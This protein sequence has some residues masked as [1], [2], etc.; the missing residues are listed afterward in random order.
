MP[1]QLAVKQK[2]PKPVVLVTLKAA[3]VAVQV[4]PEDGQLSAADPKATQFRLVLALAF[5][6]QIW[7]DTEPVGAGA[8]ARSRGAMLSVAVSVMDA[9]AVTVPVLLAC[10]VRVLGC[11]TKKH[12]LVVVVLLEPV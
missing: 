5:G 11:R 2:K 1:G 7:K 12:S 10:V 6:P 9:P 4:L 3:E 8:V